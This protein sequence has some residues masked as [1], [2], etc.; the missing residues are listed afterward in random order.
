MSEKRIL[1]LYPLPADSLERIARIPN[2]HV[3]SRSVDYLSDLDDVDVG[4]YDAII[5]DVSAKALDGAA[6]LRWL[7][8]MGAGVDHMA[9]HGLADR[10]SLT[11]T[12]GSGL[13][14]VAMGEHVLGAILFAAQRHP[15]RIEFQRRRAWDPTDEVRAVRLRGRTVTIVG[16]GTIGREIGR[17]ANAF[18]MRVL[19][20]R[21]DP[22]RRDDRG[23]DAE[24]AAGIG[25]PEGTIP[26]RIVGPDRLHEVLGEADFV[27]LA[28]PLSPSSRGMIDAAALAAMKPGAWLVNIARGGLVDEDAL[29]AVIQSGHLAGAHLDVFHLE[30]LGDTHAF[31]NEPNIYIS[32]HVAGMNSPEAFWPLVGALMEENI[33]RFA[34]DEA[35][36]N[37]VDVRRGY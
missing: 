28:T 36:L 4:Q 5:G 16:Y 19:A 10:P 31:W 6:R 14:G 1:N 25:D 11:L 7:A 13:H 34:S 8:T 22:S 18:G 27:V 30:P 26:E 33:R 20:V 24:A 37:V 29:L 35:L 9:G 3:D 21:T 12:N 17:L 23:F 15:T 2:V 32:Q